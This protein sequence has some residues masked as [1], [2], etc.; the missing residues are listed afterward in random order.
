[1]GGT[2]RTPR[3]FFK[4]RTVFLQYLL[5][6][7]TFTWQSSNVLGWVL[8]TCNLHDSHCK[9]DAL[10]SVGTHSTVWAFVSFIDAWKVLTVGVAVCSQIHVFAVQLGLQ[11]KPLQLKERPYQ[12]LMWSDE[13]LLVIKTVQ[14]A[15]ANNH[16]VNSPVA[17]CS[18]D[19]D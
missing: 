7:T 13:L 4:I 1:M 6:R 18:V 9:L 12:R 17:R 11:I 3:T 15:L 16:T 10:A 8:S 19:T 2:V 14:R 5:Q